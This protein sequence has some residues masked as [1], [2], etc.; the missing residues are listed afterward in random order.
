MRSV[1]VFCRVTTLVRS[2]AGAAT[3]TLMDSTCAV[4][5]DGSNAVV[6]NANAATIMAFAW[7]MVGT[8]PACNASEEAPTP[9]APQAA[10]RAR[11]YPIKQ[12]FREVWADIV[13]NSRPDF[14]PIVNG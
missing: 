5:T 3:R 11:Y 12:P 13:P 6:S 8:Y 4:T 1:S 2:I 14:N 10:A 9:N 7:L